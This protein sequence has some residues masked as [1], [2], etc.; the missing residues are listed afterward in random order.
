MV[1]FSLQTSTRTRLLIPEV[2]TIRSRDSAGVRGGIGPGRRPLEGAGL[3][4]NPLPRDVTL[5]ASLFEQA[6]HALH[7]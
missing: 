6:V 1:P 4:N 7:L 3:V 5:L 2:A